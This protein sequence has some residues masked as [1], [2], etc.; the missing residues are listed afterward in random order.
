MYGWAGSDTTGPGPLGGGMNSSSR[1]CQPV[2]RSGVKFG[3]FVGSGSRAGHS[4][5]PAQTRFTTRPLTNAL[6][7]GAAERKFRLKSQLANLNDAQAS[8]G[9]AGIGGWGS[10]WISHLGSVRKRHRHELSALGSLPE[11]MNDPLHF[12]ALRQGLG[13]PALP[14]P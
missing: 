9:G 6:I 12:H 10:V 11:R 3:T 14:R 2:K 13:N 7:A 4:P 5:T 1:C 8:V